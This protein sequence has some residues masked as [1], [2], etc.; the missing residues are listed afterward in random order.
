MIP[1][2]APDNLAVRKATADDVARLAAVLALAFA[3]DPA[4]GWLFP[5]EGVRQARLERWFSPALR[6]LYLRHGECY[7]NE[8]LTGAALWV[9]PDASHLGRLERLGLLPATIALFG[10]DTGRVLRAV[11]CGPRR[12][13]ARHYYLAFMGVEPAWQRRGV[14]TALLRPVLDRCDGERVGAYLEASSPANRALYQRHGF[15]AIG[16]ASLGGGPPLWPMWRPPAES[17]TSVRP[18]ER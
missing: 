11:A 8:A 10:R 6:R 15:R 7:T 2:R 4:A 3:R 5:D 1:G 14:G 9:P 16:E 18:Y 12:P 17:T 13:A